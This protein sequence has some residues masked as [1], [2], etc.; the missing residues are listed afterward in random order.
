MFRIICKVFQ[1]RSKQ[2]KTTV[3]YRECMLPINE[4]QLIDLIR[5]YLTTNEWV[6]TKYVVGPNLLVYIHLFVS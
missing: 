4:T 5:L 3:I 2:F 1:I 6:Y